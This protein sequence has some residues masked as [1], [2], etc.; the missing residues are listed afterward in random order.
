M[1]NPD[2]YEQYDY[3]ADDEEP[4]IYPRALSHICEHFEAVLEMLYGQERIDFDDLERSLDEVAHGLG[5]RLPMGKLM[6][7][8]KEVNNG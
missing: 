8:R 7:K 2:Y 3:D 1:F 4:V 6:I 5:I